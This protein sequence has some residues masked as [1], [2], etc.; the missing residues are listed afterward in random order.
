M[1]T[2][3]GGISDTILDVWAKKIFLC[4]KI[5][6]YMLNLFRIPQYSRLL[7]QAM[8]VSDKAYWMTIIL[9]LMEIKLVQGYV[10]RLEIWE[11]V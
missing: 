3:V 1:S 4:F 7:E 2:V 8:Q 6:W 10:L 5:M 11:V 9:L